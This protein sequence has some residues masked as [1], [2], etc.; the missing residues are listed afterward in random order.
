MAV[1]LV[2]WMTVTGKMVD[3]SDERSSDAFVHSPLHRVVRTGG[4]G[5]GADGSSSVPTRCEPMDLLREASIFWTALMTVV[6]SLPP[7]A[8][9]EVRIAILVCLRARY[10]ATA[11]GARRRG[12]AAALDVGGLRP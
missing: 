1:N 9:A 6:W 11:R 2:R 8:A 4:S 12:G 3:N 7:N 5:L 10:I